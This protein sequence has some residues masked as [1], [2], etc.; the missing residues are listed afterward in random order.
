GGIGASRRWSMIPRS[1]DRFPAF[2]K[3][4]RVAEIASSRYALLAMTIAAVIASQRVRPLA[5]PMTGS[6]KQ[7]RVTCPVSAGEGRSDKDHARR[8]MC[9]IRAA[10]RPIDGKPR[11]WSNSRAGQTARERYAALHSGVLG[12]LPFAEHGP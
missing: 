3:P 5:G 4:A 1:G 8:I 12:H 6:A 11:P 7:S 9:R 2:A 10:H